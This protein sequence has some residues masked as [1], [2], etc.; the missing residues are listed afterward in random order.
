MFVQRS[1]SSILALLPALWAV[2]V[3]VQAWSSKVGRLA[4]CSFARRNVTGLNRLY[5]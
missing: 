3:L 2:K 1:Y 5:C 4:V